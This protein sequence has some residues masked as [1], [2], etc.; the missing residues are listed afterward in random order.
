M[1]HCVALGGA[2]AQRA[3]QGGGGAYQVAAHALQAGALSGKVPVSSLSSPM[4][5]EAR[6]KAAA[7]A[8]RAK[9]L[10]RGGDRLARIT[11]SLPEAGGMG[12]G[13]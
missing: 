12:C 6:R 11:G 1:W 13:H 4:D 2:C 8:R 10:A 3:R 7:E 5:A 9:V